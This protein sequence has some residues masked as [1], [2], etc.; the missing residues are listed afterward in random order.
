MDI[1]EKTVIEIDRTFP[2]FTCKDYVIWE[3]ASKELLLQC[4]EGAER[5]GHVYKIDL[6]RKKWTLHN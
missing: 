4:K 5:Y 2:E 6:K 3:G 1:T